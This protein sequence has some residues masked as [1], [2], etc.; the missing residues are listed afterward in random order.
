M[1]R[2]LLLLTE[3]ISPYRIPVFNA[4]AQ[5]ADIDLHVIFLAETDATM[6]DWRVYKDE[7]QFSYQ[8]LPSFRRRW[9]GYNF[10]LNRG[11]N[12]AL[13]RFG[14][15]VILCGGYNYFASW[16][17]L[18]WASRRAV[19]FVVWVESNAY[20]HRR[21]LPAVEFLKRKFLSAC[22]AFVV[23]GIASR[24]YLK[25][26]Q[27]PEELIFTAPNAVDNEFFAGTA[28]AVKKAS[29]NGYNL[30]PR[31]F[32]YVGRLVR[33]KG[34][35]DLLAAYATLPAGLRSEIG[36]VFV[37]SGAAETQLR[38]NARSIQP[39]HVHFAGFVHKDELAR[40]YAFSD[41]LVF[42]THSDP[43][44]LVVN[45]AMACGLPVIS[46]DVAGCSA[47]LV[48]DGWNGRVIP[49]RDVTQLASAMQDLAC[50]HELRSQM[51][52]NS[53]ERIL[54]HAPF[55]CAAGLAQAALSARRAG[56]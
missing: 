15:D 24:N 34:V 20:D 51:G 23:P 8:V 25:S 52:L 38:N 49:P 21:H 45:E 39:G 16:Q 32:L 6:R 14:P 22:D 5:R 43:W 4:V 42:P 37:G 12:K 30:P 9:A 26:F 33:E 56:G 17:A 40:F 36:L 13:Q 29:R 11:L 46:S 1:K 27:I 47:D 41:V 3:I 55:N 18:R 53:R 31:F 28:A 54:M 19:P 48:N 2:K 50:N 35:F 7:I 44:G 10:L